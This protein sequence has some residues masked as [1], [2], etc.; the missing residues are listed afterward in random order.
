MEAEE[1]AAR[2][3]SEV[4]LRGT[5]SSMRLEIGICFLCVTV[6]FGVPIVSG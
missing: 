5:T 4:K 2:K 1:E 3:I 6:A